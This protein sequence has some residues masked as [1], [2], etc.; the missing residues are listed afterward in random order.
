MLQQ[1]THSSNSC[2]FAARSLGPLMLQCPRSETCGRQT[3]TVS[4]IQQ[5][6]NR[7]VTALERQTVT[8]S[9]SD[10][11]D[12]ARLF[13]V[14]SPRSSDWLFALQLS[15]WGR[16]LNDRAIDVGLWL[17]ANI[18]ENHQ[19]R[20]GA[21]VDAIGLHGLSCRGSNG[22]SARHHSLNVLVWRAIVKANIPALKKKYGERSD[23]VL[24]CRRL[25]GKCVTWDVTVSDTLAL[26]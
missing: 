20:C 19:C 25:E 21:T 6:P 1:R 26:S 14:I 18:C 13:E 24:C 10:T 15:C 9:L 16:G 4:Q 11:T 23:G 5:P 7:A 3:A 2:Y 17:G 8:N 22:R 12:K